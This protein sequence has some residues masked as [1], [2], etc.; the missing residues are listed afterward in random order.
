MMPQPNLLEVKD[1]EEKQ[2]IRKPIQYTLPT[3]LIRRVNL[4]AA[5]Q[6]RTKSDV[7]AEALT[8]YFDAIDFLTE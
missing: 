1:P 8:R 3:H 5:A 6:E 2:E 7:V 4:Q